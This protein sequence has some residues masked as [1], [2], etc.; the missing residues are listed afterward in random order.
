MSSK[1]KDV[2]GTDDFRS[3]FQA[4]SDMDPLKKEL[5]EAFTILKFAA[6]FAYCK[7]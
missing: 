3:Y 6:L 7:T 1:V 5:Q 4:L 2:G